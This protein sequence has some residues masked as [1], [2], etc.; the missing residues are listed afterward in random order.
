MLA[1]LLRLFLVLLVLWEWVCETRGWGCLRVAVESV[2]AK[3]VLWLFL[4]MLWEW[5]C[6]TRGWGCLNVASVESVHAKWVGQW[7]GW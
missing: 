4:V 7:W 5:V 6:V 3:E 1:V 2:H